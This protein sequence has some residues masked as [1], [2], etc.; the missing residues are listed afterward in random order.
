MELKYTKE[1]YENCDIY[2]ADD[3]EIACHKVKLVKCRKPHT[4]ASCGKEIAKGEEALN[5]TGFM[6]GEPVSCYTCV[7]CMDS[8]IGETRG[9]NEERGPQP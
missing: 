8:W 5:E 9:E 2:G 3:T 7:P 6:D 1:D 4:C